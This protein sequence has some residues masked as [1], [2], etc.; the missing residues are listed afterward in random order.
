MIAIIDYHAG[1]IGSIE[2]II[3][4]LGHDAVIT[5][6]PS[7]VHSADKI[8]LPGVGAFDYGMQ[9]LR[10]L[11]LLPVLEE[12]FRADTPILGICLGAQLMCKSSEEGRENGLGWIDAHVVRFKNL[13][14]TEKYLVPHMGWDSVT[15]LK[16]SRLFRDMFSKPRFY[17]VHSYYIVCSDPADRLIQNSYGNAFDSAFEKRNILGVQF[18]PEKSHKFG[19]QLLRNFIELY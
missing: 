14:G 15:P 19:K 1:N 17:F 13:V 11:N 2:N 3:K 4:K 8:I 6:D 7:T 12:K 16:E 9:K 5:S 18:H 10:N